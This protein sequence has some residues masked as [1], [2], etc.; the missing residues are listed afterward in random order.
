M[1]KSIEYELYFDG[2][3]RGNPGK[4]SSAALIIEK[5]TNKIV[6][7][8]CKYF[9]EKT[10]TNNVAEYHALL[11]G[12]N[13]M[14]KY[15]LNNVKIMGD[16]LLVVNQVKKIWKCK[17]AVL[18]EYLQKVSMKLKNKKYD[19]S[20]IPRDKNTIADK[21]ANKCLDDCK[22]SSMVLKEIL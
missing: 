21:L 13:A 17:N 5:S 8:G 10:V 12:V 14:K 3:S 4:G 18:N 7:K 11:L 9:G 16:S 1:L 2:A 6:W 15:E 20:H 19:I 22:S